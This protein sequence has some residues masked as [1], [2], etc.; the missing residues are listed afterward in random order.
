MVSSHDIHSSAHVPIT[1]YDRTS[2]FFIH[3]K[4]PIPHFKSVWDGLEML[5]D[6]KFIFFFLDLYIYWYKK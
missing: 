6:K 1:S 2:S 4:Y 5:F 3:I